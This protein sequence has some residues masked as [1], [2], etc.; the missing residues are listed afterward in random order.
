MAERTTLSPTHLRIA[1]VG[2]IHVSKSSQ[3]V[4]QPLFTQISH[5]ADVLVLCG[6]FTDYGLP[7][8]A[9][10]FPLVR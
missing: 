4:F 1:A 9:R 3:G 8:E 6:D 10:D 5:T 7:D 2:D